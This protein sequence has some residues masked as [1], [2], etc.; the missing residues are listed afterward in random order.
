ML[1][2]SVLSFTHWLFASLF[3]V[4]QVAPPTPV[5][6]SLGL[7][8]SIVGG[9][10]STLRAGTGPLL[11]AAIANLTG[12]TVTGTGATTITNL[13]GNGPYNLSLIASTGATVGADF[14]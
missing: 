6:P 3:G 11:R 13:D 14:P 8:L 9:G 1:C 2:T 10:I 4:P 12:V 5:G 7:G